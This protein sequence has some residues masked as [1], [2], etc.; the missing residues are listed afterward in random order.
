MRMTDIPFGTTDWSAVAET[1]HPGESGEALWR[2]QQFGDIRVRL[3]RYSAGYV[4]DHWCD[5]GH[6]LFCMEGDLTTELRDGRVVELKAGM[7][8]QV[9][10]DTMPHRSSSKAGTTLFIV[11]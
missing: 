6:I 2:T 9:A 3:V 5:K 11:D 10:D 8:Y 7:S 1:R 4:A